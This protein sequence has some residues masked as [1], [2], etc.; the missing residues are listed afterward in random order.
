M[1]ETS[2]LFL[3]YIKGGSKYLETVRLQLVRWLI[4]R[5]VDGSYVLTG[6][7][8]PPDIGRHHG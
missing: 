7:G 5:Q 6:E 8:R 1:T 2:L 4:S 3:I